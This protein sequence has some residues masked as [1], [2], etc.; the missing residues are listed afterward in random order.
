[1]AKS[2]KTAE[3]LRDMI[4]DRARQSR[5]FPPGMGVRV[6]AI[7]S[8]WDIDCEPPTTSRFAHAD[9]C[10]LLAQIASEL[11]EQYDLKATPGR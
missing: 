9:C 6:R 5:I 3:E 4:L 10:E 8:S 7:R 1:M 11:R 2:G